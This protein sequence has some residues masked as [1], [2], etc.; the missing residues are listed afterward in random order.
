MTA[1]EIDKLME[2]Q[3]LAERE[4]TG[5]R[6]ECPVGWWF[7]RKDEDP[8]LPAMKLLPK[9]EIPLRFIH[10]YESAPYVR[11]APLPEPMFFERRN[12]HAGNGAI[13]QIWLRTS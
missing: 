9:R 10:H 1:T 12:V 4:W 3:K 2:D 5:A 13:R 6:N 7:W 11:T 8:E